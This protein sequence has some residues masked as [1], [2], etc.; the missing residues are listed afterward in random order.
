MESV[1]GPRASLVLIWFNGRDNIVA[2]EEHS[3]PVQCLPWKMG[4]HRLVLEAGVVGGEEVAPAVEGVHG[5]L[6]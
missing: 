2:S 6:K 1:I 3:E 5:V 4:A